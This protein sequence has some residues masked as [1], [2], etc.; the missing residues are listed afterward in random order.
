MDKIET[1]R[2]HQEWIEKS[3]L[4]DSLT[5]WEDGFLKSIKKQLENKGSLSP[6]QI[7]ILERIYAEK[8]D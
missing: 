2:I 8:T 1:Y 4:S 6:K 7:E 3:L 5:E